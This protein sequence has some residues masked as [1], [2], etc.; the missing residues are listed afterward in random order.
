MSCIAPIPPRILEGQRSRFVFR[1]GTTPKPILERFPL[2]QFHREEHATGLRPIPRVQLV[3]PADVA[4][5]HLPPQCELLT[6]AVEELFIFRKV[7]LEDLHCD[8]LCQLIV[9]T[10][11]HFTHAASAEQADDAV[12]SRHHRSG[13]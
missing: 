5:L 9:E 7:R 10:L 6:E 2:E 8:G 1:Q 4:M 11:V 13:G 12:A 3:E